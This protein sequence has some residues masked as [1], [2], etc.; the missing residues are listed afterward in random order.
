MVGTLRARRAA[1]CSRLALTER[2]VAADEAMC[3]PAGVNSPSGLPGRVGG[4]IIRDG[5]GLDC[6]FGRGRYKRYL[7]ALSGDRCER[8]FQRPA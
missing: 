5:M 2:A 3:D 8:L 6:M 4:G 1:C 7:D